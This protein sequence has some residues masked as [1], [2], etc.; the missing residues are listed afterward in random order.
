[1]KYLSFHIKASISFCKKIPLLSF[2]IFRFISL[3]TKLEFDFLQLQIF[4]WQKIFYVIQTNKK[5]S[6]PTQNTQK[7]VAIRIF[8]KIQSY[9]KSQVNTLQM[10]TT[11]TQTNLPWKLGHFF[12]YHPKLPNEVPSGNLKILLCITLMLSHI[13]ILFWF[14]K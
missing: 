5:I 6:A 1:M 2:Y 14:L 4:F 13:W 10:H 12:I 8:K 7:K 3:H 9:T 11:L